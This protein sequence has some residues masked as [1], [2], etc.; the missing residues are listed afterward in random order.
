MTQ[1]LIAN[2]LGVTLEGVLAALDKL[3][4]DGLIHHSHGVITVADRA[5]LE[6]RVCECYLVVKNEFD[7]LLP[8]KLVA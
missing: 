1:Q 5:A 2:M 6:G 3:Q 4:T 8:Y 7:R